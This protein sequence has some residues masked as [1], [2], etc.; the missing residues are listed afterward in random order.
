MLEEDVINCTISHEIHQYIF[1]C[2]YILVL[3]VGVPS[4]LYSLYHAALQ[5][6]QRNELGVYLL[7]LT[8]SDLLYQASLP[9]WLQYIFQ[10]MV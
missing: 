3:V 8:V 7:N 9:L 4:N 5:L 10:V 6:K 1:S 2:V